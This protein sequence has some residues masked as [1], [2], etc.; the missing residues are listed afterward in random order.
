MSTCHEPGYRQHNARAGESKG[1]STAPLGRKLRRS[2]SRVC[3]R[4]S[5]LFGCHWERGLRSPAT[6]EWLPQLLAFCINLSKH[7]LSRT[8]ARDYLEPPRLALG[9]IEVRQVP[10]TRGYGGM[11]RA[12]RL[13]RDPKRPTMQVLRFVRP[14][15]QTTDDTETVESAHD[16]RMDQAELFFLQP[17]RQ[18]QRAL[19]RALIS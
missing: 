16:F 11:I 12:Q 3:D 17:E 15:K 13:L 19:R 18:A 14:A 6:I 2:A 9:R 10:K 7:R 5:D 8:T 1:R 4:G